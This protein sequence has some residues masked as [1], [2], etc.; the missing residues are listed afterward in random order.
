LEIRATRKLSKRKL[1]RAYLLNAKNRS[2]E[3]AV[4]SKWEKPADKLPIY[5]D[6]PRLIKRILLQCSDTTLIA[7]D[8]E[9]VNPEGEKIVAKPDKN[10]GLTK[11]TVRNLLE[12]LAIELGD[13]KE[14]LPNLIQ[15]F[16]TTAD[17]DLSVELKMF[18]STCILVRQLFFPLLS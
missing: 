14:T 18:I 16:S 15:H 7:L 5:Y 6:F 13:T 9:I 12:A 4:R 2:L 17:T 3:E 11:K 8:I 1:D 10:P